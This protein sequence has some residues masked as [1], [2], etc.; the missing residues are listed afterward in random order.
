MHNSQMSTRKSIPSRS[1]YQIKVSLR[2]AKP[3]IWR[4]LHVPSE[5]TLDQLHEVLQVAFSWQDYHLHSFTAQGQDYGPKL[6]DPLL[7][8]R[9]ERK[10]SL[11]MSAPQVGSK[12]EY[13][14]DFGDSW[15]HSIVVEKILPTQDTPPPLCLAGRRAAPPEDCGGIWGYEHFCEAIADSRH[16]DHVEL[17]DWSSA[18]GY[19][20]FDPEAFDKDAIN[21]A[22]TCLALEDAIP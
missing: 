3:P 17:L 1:D 8:M 11:R 4:R 15:E 5:I 2:G 16:P 12:V 7:S 14:Y 20:K 21:K 18:V 19:E 22:L 13:L 10:A 9:D 6:N